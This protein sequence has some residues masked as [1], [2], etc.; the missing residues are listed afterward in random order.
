MLDSEDD[1]AFL[2]PASSPMLSLAG[3][4]AVAATPGASSHP[5]SVHGTPAA[6]AAMA[7]EGQEGDADADMCEGGDEAEQQQQYG[8]EEGEM[9]ESEECEILQHTEA[10]VAALEKQLQAVPTES[11]YTEPA[12]HA[13][14]EHEQQQE[15]GVGMEEECAEEDSGSLGEQ[16]EETASGEEDEGGPAMDASFGSPAAAG[17]ASPAGFLTISGAAGTPHR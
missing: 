15:E 5:M 13:G 14:I 10:A 11:G 12:E 1:L 7:A 4:P 16:D 9:S 6:A 3:T 2:P 17:S 8:E